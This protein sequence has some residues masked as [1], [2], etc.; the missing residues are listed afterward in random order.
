MEEDI[1]NIEKKE[2]GIANE[3]PIHQSS[4]KVPISILHI[5]IDTLIKYCSI[6]IKVHKILISFENKIL[7]CS[8]I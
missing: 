3:T 5:C 7:I 6:E 4:N 2:G 8:S 1:G